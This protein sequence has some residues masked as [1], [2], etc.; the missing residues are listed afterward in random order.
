MIFNI[1]YVYLHIQSY[2]LEYQ[3][4]RTKTEKAVKLFQSGCLKEALAI[5]RTFRIG[6]TK[7]ERRTLQIASESLTGN[8]GFYQQIVEDLGYYV[9]GRTGLRCTDDG[10]S[11][12]DAEYLVVVINDD[13]REFKTPKVKEVTLE[14]VLDRLNKESAYKNLRE[15]LVKVFGYSIGIY[16]ASYGVGIDNMFGR[17]KTDAEKVSEKLKELGLKFRNEFSDAAWVYRFVISRDKDNMRI[18][19]SL[20]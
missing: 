10:L 7:E 11:Y 1:L 8:S 17:Y 15:Y 14:W 18:L 12:K 2:T 19:E 5:F 16:P 13:I 6:F 3:N 20:K 9:W 4:M